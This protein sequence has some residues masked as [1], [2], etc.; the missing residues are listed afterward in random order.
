MNEI[1][2]INFFEQSIEIELAAADKVRND[3]GDNY[4]TKN[5]E[6]VKHLVLED[7]AFPSP[8]ARHVM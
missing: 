8:L 2:L 1:T 6:D 3:Y 7:D 5:F 4:K